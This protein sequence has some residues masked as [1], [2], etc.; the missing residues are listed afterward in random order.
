MSFSD[1]SNE[2]SGP[3]GSGDAAEALDKVVDDSTPREECV[4]WA[5]E[6][7]T[8]GRSVESIVEELTAGG[9]LLDDAEEIAEYARRATRHLR[10]GLT[11]E[12]A[13]RAFQVGDTSVNNRVYPAGMSYVLGPLAAMTFVGSA[14]ALARAVR[15]LW[16]TRR[17]GSRK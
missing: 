16:R 2:M 15:R 7:M 11:Q 10:G 9:W 1:E 4:Q 5:V 12:A 8:A 17:L 3:A 6:Q 14:F 13:A